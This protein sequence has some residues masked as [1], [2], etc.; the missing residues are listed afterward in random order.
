MIALRGVSLDRHVQHE[1]SLDLKRSLFALLKG[2]YRAPER[3]SVLRDVSFDIGVGE[4]LGIIGS[5]GAGKS[6]LLKVIAGILTP[7]HG[8]IEVPGVVAPLIELG[9]GFDPDLSVYDNVVTYGVLLGLPREVMRAR[10]DEILAF[11]ELE[12]YR[13]TLVKTL[14]S[15]M[16]ARLGFAVATD[17]EA[18]VLLI[19]EVLSVGDERFRKKSQ[20]RIAAFWER[21]ITSVIVSH[22]LDFIAN[23]C[24][25]VLCLDRGRIAF[26]GAP[27]LAV[28]FYLDVVNAENP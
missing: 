14:S 1:H 15:G 26:L 23:A 18:D 4:R 8:S 13:T 11:A 5:N 2:E 19:D 9:A 25:R 24:S 6:T 20:A 3:R 22:D 17:V 12:A 28:R 7:T 21:G 27:R 16:L 10:M